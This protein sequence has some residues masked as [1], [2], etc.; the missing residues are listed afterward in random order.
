MCI[1]DSVKGDIKDLKKE[2]EKL[3]A[4]QNELSN[5]LASQSGSSTNEIYNTG[6]GS[7]GWPTP[8]NYYVTSCLL[9]TS[10]PSINTL[11]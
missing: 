2:V 11:R 3:E 6:N 4:E 5:K 1:R 10:P 9:Y 7:L 8:G